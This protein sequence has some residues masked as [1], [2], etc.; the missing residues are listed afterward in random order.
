MKHDA[1]SRRARDPDLGV[2]PGPGGRHR[3]GYRRPLS[4]FLDSAAM[5]WNELLALLSPV[6]CVCCGRED[7]ELCGACARRIRVLCA[8]PFRAEARAPALLTV[9][10]AV[11]VPVVAVGH[12]RE[13]LAQSLLSFKKLGQRRLAMQLG[14]MLARGISAAAGDQRVV[15]L[16]PVPGTAAAYRRRGFTPVLML[17]RRALKREAGRTRSTG[18]HILCDVLRKR[19]AVP[20]S[21][22][23]WSPVEWEAFR[24]GSSRA[25]GQKGL[26]RGARARRVRGS[27]HVRAGRGQ[28][29]R[30]K[31]CIIVDDVLTTGATIAEAARAVEAA[32]GLVRGAVVLAAT[33]P[34]GGPEAGV[35]ETL[36]VPATQIKFK[37][38]KG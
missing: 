19:A 4:R 30:G 15:C 11:L 3:G 9:D 22:F 28:V 14:A 7:T 17:L 34:P 8:R 37:A 13:E 6:E 21:V 18:P 16:V 31:A 36:R 24:Q 35:N 26:D 32:G 33:R 23:R 1:G 2:V 38:P 20:A 12:Y 5:A 25:A 27:M 29:I 10:G